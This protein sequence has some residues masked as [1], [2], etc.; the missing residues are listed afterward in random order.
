MGRA[1]GLQPQIPAQAAQPE[2]PLHHANG[3]VDPTSLDPGDQRLRHI[4][5]PGQVALTEPG[6]PP[7]MP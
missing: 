2:K 3:R 7:T 1:A 4:R 6:N 5:P